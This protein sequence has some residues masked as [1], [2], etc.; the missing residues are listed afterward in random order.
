MP[1]RPSLIANVRLQRRVRNL[2]IDWWNDEEV[3]FT[4]AQC[5]EKFAEMLSKYRGANPMRPLIWKMIQEEQYAILSHWYSRH[6]TEHAE[7]FNYL[8]HLVDRDTTIPEVRV[9][10]LALIEKWRTDAA[11]RPPPPPLA[12]LAMDKQSIH[13]AAAM[14][15]QNRTKELLYAVPVP[16]GQRTLDEITGVW[17]TTSSIGW[18]PAVQKVLDDMKAWGRKSEIMEE[19]DYLYR[20]LMKHLWA[21][22]NTY[23]ADTDVFQTLV[24]RLWE[25]CEESVG[26][27]AM[28]HVN[29]LC[30]VLAG[31][32]D[33]ILSPVNTK[34]NFQD[35]MAR[36]AQLDLSTEEKQR[37]AT[38][39]MDQHGTPAE[40]REAWLEA[41]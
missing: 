20:Q 38:A 41:F 10:L 27:C 16:L 34:E 18:T 33:G 12:K 30:N 14:G 36:I 15:Q 7:S 8:E 2:F 21:K 40:E 32:V 19:D 39:I 1:V 31:I 22:I 37:Q 6:V 11:S 29:R 17:A 4:L 9:R 23:R 25:E 26:T 5:E 3:H 28:G 13:T 24:M 35:E